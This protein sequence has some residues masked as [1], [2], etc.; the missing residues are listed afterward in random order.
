MKVF[1]GVTS[2]MGY[3]RMNLKNTK[4]GQHRT[5]AATYA[6]FP[7]LSASASSVTFSAISGCGIST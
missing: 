2:F 5:A 1:R 6:L 4:V 3:Q 7:N